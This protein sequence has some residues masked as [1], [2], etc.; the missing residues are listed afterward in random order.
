MSVRGIPEQDK[1]E[2]QNDS[3]FDTNGENNYPEMSPLF[4]GASGEA[5]PEP[6]KSETPK[7]KAKEANRDNA[8]KGTGK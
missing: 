2:N 5:D 7:P 6:A 3:D 4:P 8:A 1:P